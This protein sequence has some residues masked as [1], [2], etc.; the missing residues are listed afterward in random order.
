[1]EPPAGTG[2]PNDSP[3]PVE[4]LPGETRIQQRSVAEVYRRG[5]TPADQDDTRGARAP[6]GGR[7]NQVER[8]S[9]SRGR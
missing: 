7:E 2:R 6:G 8:R 9:R 1:M 3:P 5:L 4:V